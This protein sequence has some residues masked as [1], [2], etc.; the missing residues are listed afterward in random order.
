MAAVQA[1]QSITKKK[2]LCIY[3]SFL[4]VHGVMKQDT[5][6]Y[7]VSFEGLVYFL[8]LEPAELIASWLRLHTWCWDINLVLIPICGHFPLKLK[9]D[10]HHP[11]VLPPWVAQIFN[12]PSHNALQWWC[13][14]WCTSPRKTLNLFNCPILFPYRCWKVTNH[15]KTAPCLIYLCDVKT[16][17]PQ[18][19]IYLFCQS[20]GPKISSVIIREFICIRLYLL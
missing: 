16:V 14:L 9:F 17:G 6:C 15:S 12:L 20:W 5:T 10:T 8:T 18:M 11:M 7:F 1:C 4:F 19:N 2:H 3:I 13:M